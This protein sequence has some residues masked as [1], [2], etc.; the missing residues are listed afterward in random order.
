LEDRRSVVAKRTLLY[1]D[2]EELPPHPDNPKGHVLSEIEA[3]MD[4]FGYTTPVL[5]C[6][7]TGK[8]A[9]GHGRREALL[10]KLDRGEPPPDGIEVVKG[11]WRCPVVRGWSSTDDA[12]LE[13]YLVGSNRLTIAGG[14]AD[15]V[16]VARI[17]DEARKSEAGLAG[18]GYTDREI[19]ALVERV[20]GG[21]EQVS[22]PEPPTQP[23][24]HTRKGDVWQ[25][26]DHLLMCGDCRDE[27]AVAALVVDKVV[28]M[29]VTSPPYA[30]RR[31][32]DEDSGFEP[33]P[34]EEYVRW[35]E[36]VQANVASF[37]APD[38]SWLVNIKPPGD[39]LDTDLYVHDLVAA[40]VR[41]WGWHFATE[42][43]WERLGVPKGP[44]LRLKNQFEPVYQFAHA[45]WKF[46]PKQV[47][48][49][50]DNAISNVGPGGGNTAWD[51]RQGKGGVI[52]DGQRRRGHASRRSIPEMQG[53]NWEPGEFI[54]EGM[55]YP[56]NRLP[57]FIQTHEALG[58]SAAFPVGLPAFFARL[59]TDPGDLIYDPFMGSGST[60][61][62]AHQEGRLAVGMEISPT[63][64]DIACRRF[65]L[66]T[67]IVPR[68]G[69]RQV[70]FVD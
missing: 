70:S 50:T 57:S 9:E 3:S 35:F 24:A 25:L 45:R 64:C 67:G 11:R 40:H 32:Y 6:E 10:A 23:P 37:L 19:D 1:M 51:E 5:I 65:Q 49:A 31:K 59:F 4:R 43:C 52:P 56:G 54:G 18:L 60:I 20:T 41:Q 38:G 12:E 44:V 53:A 58:H 33:I 55:A 7:R 63:Y 46:R 30:D 61:M 29:A 26:G 48:H 21:S 22:K 47:M 27:D 13:R 28:N 66:T 14:M 62:A 34:P 68:R 17:L 8:I 42:F 2:V 69:T 15:E 36:T 39:D 16:A